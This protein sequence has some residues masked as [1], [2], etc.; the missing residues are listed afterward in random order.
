MGWSYYWNIKTR[1]DLLDELRRPGR[2]AEGTELLHS[3]AVGNNHW[4]LAKTLETE[5]V[6]IGLDMMAGGGRT[7]EGWGYKGMSEDAGPYVYNCPLHLLAK[8]SPA[9]G[10]AVGWRE[11]VREYHATR[12]A[13]PVLTQGALIEYGGV[14]YRLVRPAS[15]RRGWHVTRASDGQPFR[16]KAVQLSQATHKSAASA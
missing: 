13:R 1:R 15:P 7:G 3:T 12:A 14:D 8:A 9:T 2:F 4:Y 5:R 16:M 10:Y 11:K 6:W